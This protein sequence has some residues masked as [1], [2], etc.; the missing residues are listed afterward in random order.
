M[1]E[2]GP[3]GGKVR[4]MHEHDLKVFKKKVHPDLDAN[5]FFSRLFRVSKGREESQA[6]LVQRERL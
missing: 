4:W 2:P 1:G 3:A 6:F 5:N